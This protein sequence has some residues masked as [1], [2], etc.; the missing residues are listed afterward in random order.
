MK[1]WRN[2]LRADFVTL[3][4]VTACGCDVVS[5]TPTAA[6]T[7]P[8]PLS[9]D[10][11]PPAEQATVDLFE[12]VSPSVVYITTLTQRRNV[13]TG[14]STEVPQGTGSGFVWDDAG[15]IV[16]NLH[17]LQGATAAQVVLYDQS[18][19]R[20][21]LVGFSRGH[22]LAVLRIDASPD[23]LQPVTVGRSDDLRVGQSIFAIGNPFGLNATLTTGIV[24]ALGREIAAVG[25]G[26][27]ENA[28]QT[29]AAINPG[30]SG[31]PLL[32]SA[33][34]LIGVN[35][36]IY[37]PSGAS[38]GIGF[39]VPVDT[40]RRVIPQV[41][42]NGEYTPP[43]LGIRANEDLNAYVRARLRIRGVVILEVVPGTDGER[44]G[45]QGT[46]R[47]ADGR[48]ILGDIVQAVDGDEVSDLGD[49]QT[50]L[51]RYSPGDEVTVTILRENQTR[52]VR[53]QLF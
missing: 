38:A 13:F 3:V 31:G 51:D 36:A 4:L 7:T 28:I 45:L 18:N 42:E 25:G 6:Q 48:L 16:T 53:I 15:H 50:V 12:S 44:A 52:D 19:Y 23:V 30:N 5:T 20:A 22:D 39:A 43:Q 41:I 33:A 32:D 9:R 14:V 26:T 10:A 49:L 24:S 27:I 46:S 2:R 8:P 29:D 47:A 37:S 11:L 1:A 17:V 40:V 34:R 35:T 21:E